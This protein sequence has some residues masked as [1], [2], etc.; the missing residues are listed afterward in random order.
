MNI[1]NFE[2]SRGDTWRKEIIFYSE[3]GRV[4][5]TDWKLFFTVKEKI[6][7]VDASAKISKTVIVHTDPGQGETLIFLTSTDTDI[8]IGNYIYDIQIV[9]PALAD[10]R[11]ILSGNFSILSDVTKRTA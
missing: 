1:Q 9:T 3:T 7:D 2:I 6:T 4:N 10:V 11:T 5:I 8:A